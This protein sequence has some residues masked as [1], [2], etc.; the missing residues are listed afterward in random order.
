LTGDGVHLYDAS[1]VRKRV[2]GW[3]WSLGQVLSGSLFSV[4][5]N[6]D[7]GTIFDMTHLR[8]HTTLTTL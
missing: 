2:A 8:I 1:G 3:D 6:Q 4:L 5:T 7:I